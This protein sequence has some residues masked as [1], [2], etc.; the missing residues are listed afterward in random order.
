[1]QGGLRI[2]GRQK[3]SELTSPLVSIITVVFNGEAHLEQ[4][5][6]SVFEQTYSNIEY[7]VIDGGS[8]DNTLNIIKQ[9]EN[10]ID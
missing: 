3:Q 1:M 6:N 8:T 7:I 4:T 10:K 5:F 9:Y 2:N